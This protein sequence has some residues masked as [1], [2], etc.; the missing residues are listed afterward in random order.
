MGIV[1]TETDQL[2]FIEEEVYVKF[3]DKSE[4]LLTTTTDL[5]QNLAKHERALSLRDRLFPLDSKDRTSYI[6]CDHVTNCIQCASVFYYLRIP[7]NNN[8][9]EREKPEKEEEEE[10]KYIQLVSQ[11]TVNVKEEQLLA[12]FEFS[13][14][15]AWLKDEPTF[16]KNNKKDDLYEYG[17]G[18]YH[19]GRP[20][21]D[22]RYILF[23]NQKAFP[24]IQFD[25][26][27]IK[28]Q[29]FFIVS[30]ILE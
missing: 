6:I 17:R 28:K 9:G 2:V 4:E 13:K 16:F 20:T 26:E 21:N 30:K 3:T 7:K 22:T 24:V 27:K 10:E 18:M 15:Y 23:N 5:Q 11:D 25:T 19:D 8:D 29:L 14:F 1:F 12:T